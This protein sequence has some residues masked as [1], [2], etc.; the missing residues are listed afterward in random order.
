MEG[1]ADKRFDKSITDLRIASQNPEPIVSWLVSASADIYC[2]LLG[3]VA[4]AASG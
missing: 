3:V 4:T 2:T 1:A